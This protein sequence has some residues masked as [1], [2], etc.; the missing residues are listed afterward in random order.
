MLLYLR[1]V[2]QPSREHLQEVNQIIADLFDPNI[3]LCLGEA[4]T[5]S[6]SFLNN[7][8]FWDAT[9]FIRASLTNISADANVRK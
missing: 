3:W 4:D 8:A 5:Y 6:H 9:F 2:K 7:P 1:V